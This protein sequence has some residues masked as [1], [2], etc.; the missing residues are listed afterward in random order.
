MLLRTS[1]LIGALLLLPFVA[2]ASYIFNPGTGSQTCSVLGV[3]GVQFTDTESCSWCAT[4]SGAGAITTTL[5]S[6]PAVFASRS[7]TTGM[8]L[9]LLLAITCP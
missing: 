8:S 2:E 5:I 6:C 1:L 7:C 4:T 9:G 3:D